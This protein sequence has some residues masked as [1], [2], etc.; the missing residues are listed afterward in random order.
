M[1][2]ALL[3]IIFGLSILSCSTTK[4]IENKKV[5]SI[6]ESPI[7]YDYTDRIDSEKLNFIRKTYNWNNEKILILN[8]SQ[9]INSC[10]FDNNKITS[11]VKKWWKDFYSKINTEDCLNIKVLA[12]G[13]RVKNK[14]DNINYFDD[15][16]DFVLTN[17]FDRKKSCF[18][19]LVMNNEGYYIQYNG[20]YSEKQVT[21]YIYGIQKK[22][23]CH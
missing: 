10:H 5:D 20:H 3:N 6:N 21:K 12:N 9:P 1:K 15:K 16:N 18:G 22:L 14:L 17:F 8:Y 2:K 4:T 13:E 19:V 7:I 11:E 23:K